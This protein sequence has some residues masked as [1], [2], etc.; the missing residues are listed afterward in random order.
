M[1]RYLAALSRPIDLDAP[2][3]P[4][5]AQRERERLGV[6]LVAKGSRQYIART[7]GGECLAI[8]KQQR[9]W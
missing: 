7:V 9:W 3:T 8:S 1:T 5:A 2:R 4:Y 6:R